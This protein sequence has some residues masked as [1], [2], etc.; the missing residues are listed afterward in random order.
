MAAAALIL[1]GTTGQVAASTSAHTIYLLPL[2]A[3]GVAVSSTGKRCFAPAAVDGEAYWQAP[4]IAA[5]Q[6][7]GGIVQVRIDLNS[8]GTLTNEGIFASSGNLFLDDAALR[9]AVLT[10]FVPEVANCERVGGSYLY[11]VD[12]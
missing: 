12:F 2:S 8:A 10:K 7:V 9:S 5:E 6:G 1:C 4:M 11:E 3:T